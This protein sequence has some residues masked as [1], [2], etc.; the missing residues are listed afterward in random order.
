MD[1]TSTIDLV[2]NLSWLLLWAAEMHFR[3]VILVLILKIVRFIDNRFY[4]VV[5]GLFLCTLERLMHIF[6]AMLWSKSFSATN[7]THWVSMDDF[8]MYRV[9]IALLT[10]VES[11]MVLLMDGLFHPEVHRDRIEIT[12]SLG[13]YIVAKIWLWFNLKW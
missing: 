13:S 4:P 7:I 10:A 6:N 3:S 9:H 12:I 8:L 2:L 11:L 1:V 5:L